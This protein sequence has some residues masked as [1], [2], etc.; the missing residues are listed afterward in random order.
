M[1]IG[2]FLHKYIELWSFT[3][4]LLMPGRIHFD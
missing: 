3:S 2:H 1:E 4:W